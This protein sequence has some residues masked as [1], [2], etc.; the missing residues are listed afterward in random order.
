M[1]L[2]DR[3]DPHEVRAQLVGSVAQYCQ[4]RQDFDHLDGWRLAATWEDGA[5]TLHTRHL[6]ASAKHYLGKDATHKENDE[7]A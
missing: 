1:R 6:G 4:P 3:I 2:F 5:V 7:E